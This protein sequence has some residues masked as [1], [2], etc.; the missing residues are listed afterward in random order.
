MTN[1]NADSTSAIYDVVSSQAVAIRMGLGW[2]DFKES[3]HEEITLMGCSMT[4]IERQK[5]SR[6]FDFP[7][8]FPLTASQGVIVIQERRRLPDRRREQYDLDDL[9]DKVHYLKTAVYKTPLQHALNMHDSMVISRILN[10][11]SIGELTFL[12][13]SHD[14][15]NI[16]DSSKLEGSYNIDKFSSDGE[17]TMGLMNLGLLS[18]SA[19]ERTSSDVGA[20]HFTPLADRLVR[21]FAKQNI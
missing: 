5:G 2:L 4:L 17:R 12:L 1:I 15:K 8:E 13:E 10:Q 7:V 11:I 18:R 19:A 20:Y 16:L 21:L 14:P 3:C 9:D 6:R